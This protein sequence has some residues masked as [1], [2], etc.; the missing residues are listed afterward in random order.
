MRIS[1][2]Q[3]YNIATLG[4]TQAQTALAKTQEQLSTGKRVLSPADDPVAATAIL[5]LNQE[6]ARTEQFKKN[7]DVAD[8]SL[9]LEET[10]LQSIVDLV[11]KMRTIAVSAGNT[12]VMTRE[13]YLSL[14]AEVD[15]R[16]AELVNLQNTR[17]ASGQYIFAGY[18]SSTQPFVSDGGGN[19]SYLGDEGQL[20]LQASASVSVAVSDSGKKLFVDIPS[21]H[22]TFTTSASP[23]NKAVPPALISVGQV[24]DQQEF[25]KLYP[26]DL[27]VTFT[28]S[29]STVNF[30]VSERASGKQLL[31][32]QPYMAGEDIE[33]AGARFKILGNPYPGESAIAS[34]IP[35]DVATPVGAINPGDTLRITVAGKTEEFT[36]PAGVA[37][38]DTAG[39]VAAL[40]NGAAVPPAL[41]TGNAAKLA[42][43]GIAVDATGFSS[44]A[45][46]NITLTD[47]VGTSAAVMMGANGT[48]SVNMPF[49]V[50]PAVI[51]PHDFSTTPAS[52]QLEVNGKTE[53]LTFNQNITNQTDLAAAFNDPANAGQLARLGLSVTDKGIISNN[54]STISIKGGNTFLDGVMGFGTQGDGTKSTRGVLVKPGDSFFVESSDKQA[55]LTTLS[56]FSDAMKSVVDTP[57]SKE[58]L[59]KLVAKTITNLTNVVTNLVAVQGEVGARLNT[60]ESSASLNLDIILFTQT[61]LS[62]LESVDVAEATIRL[63]MQSLILNASQ[64]SFAKV[65][66]LTL[67][68]YL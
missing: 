67:F 41:P 52:F 23:G 20:R 18:Q 9:D 21:G 19:F 35:F 58:E 28:K 7:V 26:N 32:N 15:T 46:L 33:V 13:N 3:I 43:L 8:N 36:F 27:V 12:A 56:R 53:T 25:D 1:T 4:M 14:A 22:N 10:N 63:S 40:N 6:L 50:A 48:R 65:S 11:Q 39:F 66:Q 47:G 57:E 51:T 16:I 29:G 64:Q 31:V 30:T 38:G 42:N 55:L 61:T 60:L 49:P 37:A 54:N 5:Q 2:S 34:T 44:A 68:S 45:G 59:G 24:F 62:S 17:N